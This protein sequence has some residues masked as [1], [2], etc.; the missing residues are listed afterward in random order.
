LVSLKFADL[1]WMKTVLCFKKKRK[2]KSLT[3]FDH[4]I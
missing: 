3:Y 4:L 1:A 2:Y